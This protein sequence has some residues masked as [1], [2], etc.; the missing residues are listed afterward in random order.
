MDKD[1]QDAE[2]L[3]KALLKKPKSI[4]DWDSLTNGV[5]LLAIVLGVVFIVQ[6]IANWAYFYD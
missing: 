2:K 3:Q 1:R 5:I 4:I 6:H